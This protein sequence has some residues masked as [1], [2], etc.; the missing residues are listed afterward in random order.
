MNQRREGFVMQEGAKKSRMTIVLI[1]IVIG[2]FII[3]IGTYVICAAKIPRGYFDYILQKEQYF[4][5]YSEQYEYWD[6]L[7]V[8]YPQLEE[9]EE[10]QVEQI[11][12]LL[13]N[14]AMDRINYWHLEP[15]E[16]V[17]LLQEQ[18]Q[19][20]SSD[21]QSEVTFHSQYL[22]SVSFEEIY[23]PINPVAYVNITERAINI[24]LLTGNT[25]QL[26]DIFEINEG[27]IEV[28]CDAARKKYG[29]SFP[30]SDE[31][32]DIMLE[33]FHKADQEQSE[34]YD[35]EPFFYITSNKEFVIGISLNPKVAGLAGG[36]PSGSSYSVCLPLQQIDTYC[37][38]SGFW[39]QYAQ[40]E[41]TGEVRECDERRENLWLGKEG[42][43][44]SYWEERE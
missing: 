25:Y 40:S 13:Y 17:R 6:V 10:P 36:K 4:V 37:T 26:E 38:D 34:Y 41:S 20:F 31:L 2:V 39:D 43:V 3:G 7:T 14:I 29:K 12:E 42:S 30:V 22:L 44:W 28:W 27:F 15:N 9:I 24:D 11:N 21:V 33:W 18:Y 8:E 32:H 35:F 23:A 1:G 16:E 5:Q 19:I